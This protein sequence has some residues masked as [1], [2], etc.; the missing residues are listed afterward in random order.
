MRQRLVIFSSL[1]PCFLASL[2]L[3]NGCSKEYFL[4]KYYLIKAEEA[5]SKAYALRV[6]HEAAEE[7]KEYYRKARE[8]FFKA[9]QNFPKVFTL[10]R[11]EQAYDTCL[12]LEDKEGEGIFRRFADEYVKEHPTEAEYGDATPLLGGVE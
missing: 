6:K 9:Y 2:L 4:A 7:R 5:Y 1:L 10:N 3:F 12:R 11:I 8:Y